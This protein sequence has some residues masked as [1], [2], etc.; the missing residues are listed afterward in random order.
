MKKIK[1]IGLAVISA[2]V[3]F[4]CFERT[5]NPLF[6]TAGIFVLYYGA[7][8]WI[9]ES[10]V[11]MEGLFTILLFPALIM[12]SIALGLFT[13]IPE[14]LSHIHVSFAGILILFALLAVFIFSSY[15]LIIS[16]NI[17]NVSRYKR[18]PLLQAAQTIVYV[19]SFA[20]GYL[21]LNLIHHFYLA[22][23][24]ILIPIYVILSGYLFYINNWSIKLDA[25]DN[26]IF[27]ALG[28]FVIAQIAI[29]LA[30]FPL[31]FYVYPLAITLCI[32]IFNGILIHVHKRN[33]L[34]RTL[35][36]YI[37]L[38]AVMLLIILLTSQWGVAGNII[39]L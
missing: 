8:F 5:I 14:F 36:E 30:F 38:G 18:L 3:S 39:G 4:I 19:F 37:G 35:L 12:S 7:T 15:A 24:Y 23:W 26:F 20:G 2:I 28:M 6:L 34:S 10:D 9:M 17:F 1:V 11:D 21:A 33:P 22:S 13:Y 27:T 25:Q 31:V 29:V 16:M 32:Y